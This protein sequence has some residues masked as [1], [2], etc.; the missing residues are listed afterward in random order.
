[1]RI[2]IDAR[3]YGWAGLG[4][5]VRNLLRHLT[6]LP[7]A[8]E[9]VVFVPRVYAREIAEMP[10]VRVVPVASSYYSLREQTLFLALLLR[11]RVDL[12]HFLHFN[13]P[14]FYRR[15]SVVTIHDLTRF[16]FPAQKHTGPF[17]Q[18]A[19][20]EVF[21]AAIV[22]AR[23]V[24]AVSEHTRNDLLRF[25]PNVA[26]RTVVIPEG[27]EHERYHTTTNSAADAAALAR[28]GI[29][30][31]YLLFVGVWMNHKNL[32]RLL[33]AF[34][35]VRQQGFAGQLVITGVGR[36]HD[37]DVPGLV[38]RLRLSSSV[39]LPGNVPEQILPILYRQA[40]VFVFP[41]LYEGFGFPP[42]E[43]MAC[44]VP[45]VASQVASLPEVLGDAADF[46]DPLSPGD[47]ARG[48]SRVLRDAPHR[49]GLIVRGLERVKR[50][51]W[52]RCAAETLH[53]YAVALK[54]E[55]IPAQTVV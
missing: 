54:E 47:I 52:S 19:Y 23:R 28:L 33:E 20:E 25:F 44:G 1:M 31:P 24:I 43:A 6:G 40:S 39:I 45:V 10:R 7:G 8:P 26:D 42:L 3:A 55:R 29:N 16:L 14:V 36:P 11:Y 30:K 48:V 22:H 38:R 12:M 27:I 4:R 32:P 37:E 35:D 49:E 41:S 17:H 50:Y 51:Q 15:P 21:R 18:W 53:V 46:V 9:L 2:G 5:Y 34:T 13:A